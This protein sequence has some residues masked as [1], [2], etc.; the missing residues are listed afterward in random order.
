M[1]GIIQPSM[2]ICFRT[3]ISCVTKVLDR[4]AS[5]LDQLKILLKKYVGKVTSFRNNFYRLKNK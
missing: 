4:D 5:A 2:G 3:I 1:T